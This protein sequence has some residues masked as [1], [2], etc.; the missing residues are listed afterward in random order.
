MARIDPEVLGI[1]KQLWKDFL[2]THNTET[3]QKALEYLKKK[4]FFYSSTYEGNKD[5]T[6]VNEGSRRVLLTIETILKMR[7]DE[8]VSEPE[9]GGD[10]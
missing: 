7:F 6:L 2:Q 10:G 1:D 5:E 4:F 9:G 3:G 8:Q